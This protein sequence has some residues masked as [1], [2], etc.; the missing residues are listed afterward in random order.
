[1]RLVNSSRRIS[2]SSESG[3][4]ASES[5]PDLSSAVGTPSGHVSRA[6][7][8][9]WGGCGPEPALPC[10]PWGHAL[11]L[12]NAHT[13]LWP[14]QG[15]G[16]TG[17]SRSWDRDV[18]ELGRALRARPVTG[19]W[20][21]LLLALTFLITVLLFFLLQ[22]GL[23]FF[24]LLEQSLLQLPLLVGLEQQIGER[25]GRSAGGAGLGGLD[26]GTGAE[27]FLAEV[28][29]DVLLVQQWGPEPHL[30]IAEVLPRCVETQGRAVS[31]SQ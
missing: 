3:T 20:V 8:Q 26:W 1:M 23:L 28:L 17:H 19:C 31:I 16:S 5:L 6:L 15:G 10:P 29:P 7:E 11:Q 27:F 12:H 14:P 21:P 30:L 25:A 18:G 22:A 13:V 24:L 4:Q 2:L 9:H